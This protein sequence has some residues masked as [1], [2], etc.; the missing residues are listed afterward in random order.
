MCPRSAGTPS[1]RHIRAVSK[2]GVGAVSRDLTLV[3]APA[4]IRQRTGAP[5][6]QTLAYRKIR[7]I[8]QVTAPRGPP[9]EMPRPPHHAEPATELPQSS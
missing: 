9:A 3:I 5:G 2:I 4:V 8:R 6:G 7:R 1:P